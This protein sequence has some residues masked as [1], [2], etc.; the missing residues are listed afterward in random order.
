MN[1]EEYTEVVHNPNLF[2]KQKRRVQEIV[3]KQRAH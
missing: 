2:Y 1:C 3:K